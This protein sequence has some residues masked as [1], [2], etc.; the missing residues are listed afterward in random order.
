MPAVELG[1]YLMAGNEKYHACIEACVECLVACAILYPGKGADGF[2][3]RDGNDRR[4]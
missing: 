1:R 2:H 4:S 3:H